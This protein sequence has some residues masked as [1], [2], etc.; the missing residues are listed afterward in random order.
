[1]GGAAL[2]LFAKLTLDSSE[3]DDKLKGKGEDVNKFASFLGGIGK[4]G[5]AAFAAVGTATVAIGKQAVEAYGRYEQ[6]EGGIEKI[7][8]AE[9]TQTVMQNAQNAFLTAGMSAN[10]YMETVTGISSALKRS[11]G[12][13]LQGVAEVA[14][15]AMRLISDN[16]NTFGSDYESVSNAITALSRNNYTLIDNLK[17]GY[18]GTAEG[19]RQ[20]INDSG[21]LG[22]TLKDTSELA[23]VGFDQMILAIQ[24]V[25][26]AG[27][28][29]GTT[30]NEALKT[31]EG[32]STATKRAWENVIT[33]IGRGEGLQEAFSGLSTALFGNGEAGTGFLAQVIPRIQT[34]MEGIGNAI[35][36]A[37][38]ILAEK[39]PQVLSAIL[40]SVAATVS[41]LTGTI[42]SFLASNMPSLISAGVNILNWL[43]TGI[44]N[45]FPQIISTALQIIT[46]F[47]GEIVSNLPNILEAGINIIISLVNGI[48]NSIPQV[49]SA[50]G[51]LVGKAA[52]AFKKFDWVGL[53][54]NIVQGI[55]SGISSLAGL[56]GDKLKDVARNAWDGVKNFF[57]ISSPSKLMRD[58]VG[59]FI[60]LGIAEGIEDA[61]DSVYR[62]MDNLN[63]GTVGA[64]DSVLDEIP[65]R[66]ISS[67]GEGGLN[68]GGVTINVY[69]SEGMDEELLAERIM[70]KINTSLRKEQ[71]IYG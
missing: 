14:D 38:P 54:A 49:I 68:Y 63:I 30:V 41:S 67:S 61:A 20:L 3:F 21:V 51:D 53:G 28:I 58:T 42:I 48:I 4:V 52:E 7:F 56:I 34:T 46:G 40:P 9:A 29:A 24:S 55:A 36:Q 10:Q 27:N 45:N 70:R 35:T 37:A 47:L 25:Q 16:V 17:L 33:A 32:S 39:I 43:A 2:D 44:R 5:A 13:D 8:G 59:K 11:M 62:A 71:M 6:L 15:V 23:N 65:S 31:L 66:R 64:Y 22:Y 26:E 19:M 12:D 50:I 69:P 60:P 18:A 1:M 57:G